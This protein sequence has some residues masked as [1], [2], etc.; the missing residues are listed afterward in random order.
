MAEYDIEPTLKIMQQGLDSLSRRIEAM[1]VAK[2][3]NSLW[4]SRSVAA[5]ED[6][7]KAVSE[8]PIDRQTVKDFILQ[9][10]YRSNQPRR[11][12]RRIEKILSAKRGRKLR[13]QN[14]MVDLA[15]VECVE[16]GAIVMTP[17][18]AEA[19]IDWQ[20]L[21]DFFEKMLPLILTLVKLFGGI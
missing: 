21:A 5:E 20:A 8:Q 16:A 2:V 17:D 13:I 4:A 11:I 15:I 9:A 18:G 1:E 6:A 3:T 14:Q 7:T 12:R 10:A 19:A